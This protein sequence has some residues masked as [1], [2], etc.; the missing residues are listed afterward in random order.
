[1]EYYQ[2]N[3]TKGQAAINDY[4]DGLK[5]INV[6][7]NGSKEEQ[8]EQIITQKWIAVFP[9][10]NEGWA[11]FRRTDYPALANILQNTSSDVP[12]GK[13]IKRVRY[14]DNESSNPNK[15]SALQGDRVWWDVADTNNDN[16]ARVTPNNFR[17]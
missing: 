9:N 2:I 16:G 3:Q 11:E 5:F 6:F 4:I 1:M 17:N 7:D 8:L 15:P 14:P 10:G 12:Q 13:F